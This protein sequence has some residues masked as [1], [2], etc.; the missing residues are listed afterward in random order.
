MTAC[1]VELDSKYFVVTADWPIDT[2]KE[3][4]AAVQHYKLKGW[5]N[6]RVFP[7]DNWGDAIYAA[8]TLGNDFV[9]DF[10]DQRPRSAPLKR[11]AY[12]YAT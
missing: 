4:L 5:A 3:A 10:S 1:V 8:N 6:E 2:R 9:R 7:Y 12:R 11:G